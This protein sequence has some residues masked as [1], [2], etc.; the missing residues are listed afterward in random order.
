M[1]AHFLPLA[2]VTTM[3]HSRRVEYYSSNNIIINTTWITLYYAYAG[4]GLVVRHFRQN[5]E[6]GVLEELEPIDE[7]RRYDFN[8]QQA[9]LLPREVQI[10]PVSG[11]LLT[12]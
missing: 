5:E 9:T 7:N 10:L 3:S 11:N 1:L 2:A 8:Y 4:H 6:C 12:Y